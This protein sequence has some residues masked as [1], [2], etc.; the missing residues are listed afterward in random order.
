MEIG[1]MW[2]RIRGE[3]A[4]P[5]AP[6]GMTLVEIMIVITIMASIMGVVGYYV[7]GTLNQAKTKNARLGIQKLNGIVESYY[8][9]NSPNKL[10]ESL[11]EL[12]QG[13]NPLI[14][15]KSKLNDPWGNRYIY[16]KKG[17]QNFEIYSVGPDGSQGTEDDV[18]VG[19]S[20]QE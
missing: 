15:E 8:L 18:F 3:G 9:M 6:K 16:E 11:D 5:A 7:F 12:T 4:R 19:E 14:K 10:P 20:G 13:P 17:N 2:R 1:R